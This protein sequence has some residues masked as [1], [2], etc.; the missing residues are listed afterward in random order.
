MGLYNLYGDT[1]FDGTRGEGEVPGYH[2]YT[3][4]PQSLHS[5]CVFVKEGER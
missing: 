5:V 2:S 3:E 1:E 4:Q